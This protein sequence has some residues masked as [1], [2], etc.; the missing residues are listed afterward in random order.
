M[1]LSVV[2]EACDSVMDCVAESGRIDGGAVGGLMLI[3]PAPASLDSL[4]RT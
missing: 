2:A 4:P 3:E 1:G